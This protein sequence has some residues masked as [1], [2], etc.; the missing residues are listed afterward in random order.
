MQSRERVPF[1]LASLRGVP[2][3]PK[4]VQV[5]AASYWKHHR[6]QIASWNV[7]GSVVQLNTEKGSFSYRVEKIDTG[8]LMFPSCMDQKTKNMYRYNCTLQ[9]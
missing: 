3:W 8:M 4:N 9:S 6:T 2:E 1:S 7:V 5:A